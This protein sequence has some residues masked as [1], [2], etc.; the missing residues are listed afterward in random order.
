MNILL[1]YLNTKKWYLICGL[2]FSNIMTYL[3]SLIT[4]KEISGSITLFLEN[5]IGNNFILKFF[6]KLSFIHLIQ[7]IITLFMKININAYIGSIFKGICSKIH[8]S[9]FITNKNNIRGLLAN[10]DT[11]QQLIE[12]FLIDVPKI[13]TLVCYYIYLIYNI[14]PNILIL[15]IFSNIGIVYGLNVFNKTRYQLELKKSK[16]NL[17]IKNTLLE[18]VLNSEFIKLNNM[19]SNEIDDMNI[20]HNK[21]LKNQ[22]HLQRIDISSNL[23]SV[24]SIDLLTLVIYSIGISYII[25]KSLSLTELLYLG[26]ITNYFCY[27]IIDL[28]NIWTFLNINF[29]KIKSTLILLFTEPEKNEDNMD[30]IDKIDQIEQTDNINKTTLI[31][32]DTINDKSIIFHNVTFSYD[33]K[34]NVINNVNFKFFNKKINLLMGP[35]GSGK[36]TLIK[37]LLRLYDLPNSDSD[38]ID[39]IDEMDGRIFFDGMCITKTDINIL[40]KRIVFLSQEPYIFDSSVLYNIQYGNFDMDDAKFNERIIEMC[41]VINATEWFNENYFKNVGFRGINIG[42]SDRK[43][44]QL[45]NALCKDADVMIFDEPTNTLDL[46]AIVWFNQFVKLLRDKYNKTII[47]ISHDIRLRSEMDHIVDLSDI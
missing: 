27:K 11:I 1:E 18:S 45:L 7:S 24:L 10:L 21:F 28:L 3:Y 34:I 32:L 22:Q 4:Y 42:G 16:H 14:S 12:K 26:L 43:K 44:I 47:I 40:R 46:N 20:L 31:P 30:N 9:N 19:E 33:N 8:E 2:L 29:A 39:E 35:N 25:T 41:D 37:L 15:L 23:L 5:Y 17:L 6:I 38:E 36:S 13:L